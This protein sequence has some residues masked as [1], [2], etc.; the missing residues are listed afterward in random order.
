[1]PTSYITIRPIEKQENLDTH[2]SNITVDSC[3]TDFRDT[4]AT[5]SHVEDAIQEGTSRQNLIEDFPRHKKDGETNLGSTRIVRCI[6]E[7]YKYSIFAR[8][9]RLL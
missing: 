6:Q 2:V 7:S 5:M 4:C 1:M 9:C 8:S 3:G